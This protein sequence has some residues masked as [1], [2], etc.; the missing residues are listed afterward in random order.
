MITD[1]FSNDE[2]GKLAGY[3]NQFIEKLNEH[4][5]QLEAEIN[6]R[7]R[8]ERTFHTLF[9][10][11]FQFIALLDPDGRVCKINKTALSFRN[12]KEADVFGKLFWETPWW[13]HSQR[14]S[15]N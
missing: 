2:V 8:S 7:E 12:L 13:R 3:L 6:E 5:V 10:H 14:W 15:R 9:D 11:S 4:H 1:Q